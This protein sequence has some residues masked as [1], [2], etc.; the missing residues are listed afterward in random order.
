MRS[1]FI[2][3]LLPPIYILIVQLSICLF[4]QAIPIKDPMVLSKI[5]QTYRIGYLKVC[6]P[7]LSL[8]CSHFI[9]NLSNKYL[10]IVLCQDVVLPRVLD[11]ATVASLNSIVHANNGV[12]SYASYCLEYCKLLPCLRL[13][14]LLCRQFHC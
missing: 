3:C 14:Q 4:S 2:V 6:F 8:I 9:I 13:E 7:I 1:V 10:I 5:H 11:D 12:V